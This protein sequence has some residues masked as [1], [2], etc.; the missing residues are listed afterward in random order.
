MQFMSTSEKHSR[1]LGVTQF[2][3]DITLRTFTHRNKQ[4]PRHLALD[5]SLFT[6]CTYDD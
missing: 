2:T 3:Q 6:G 5:F 1:G 4:Q